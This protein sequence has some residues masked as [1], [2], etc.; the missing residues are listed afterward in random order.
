[1]LYLA[2]TSPRRQEL[3]QQIKIPFAV[4]KSTYC[5]EN[6]QNLQ[7]HE[8]VMQHALGKALGADKVSP[9]E[10]VILGADTVVVWDGKVLGKPCDYEEARYMLESLSGQMHTVVTGVALCYKDWQDVFY[11]STEV[12]F[13]KITSEEIETY[14]QSDEAFDKAGAYAVQGYAARWVKSINGSYTNVVGLPLAEVYE[15]LR[16]WGLCDE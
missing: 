9:E 2:S 3:L 6:K 15:R 12:T 13:T 14:L 11:V 8:L 7:P 16:I 1:M 10:H 5:E 4:C